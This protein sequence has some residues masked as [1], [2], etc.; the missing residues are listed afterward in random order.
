VEKKGK[1]GGK[2]RGRRRRVRVREKGRKFAGLN[3]VTEK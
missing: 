1:G 2:K 3:E